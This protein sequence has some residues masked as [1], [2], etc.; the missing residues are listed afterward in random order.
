MGWASGKHAL[1]TGAG[2]GIG[3]AIAAALAGE[4]ASLSL[5]GRRREPLEAVAAAT[6]GTVIPCDITDRAAQEAAFA[7][8]RAANGAL[9]FLILNA[10]IADS[11][12]FARTSRASFDAI[13]ATNLTAAF[14]GAQIALPDL[15][16]GPGKRLIFIAS[17]AGLK[18][19]AYAA[20]Y[21]ASKHGVIGLMKS[22]AIEFAKSGMTVNA[23]CPSFVD[24]PMVDASVARVADRSGRSSEQARAAITAMN[25]SDR[26]ITADEVAAAALFLCRP[27][28]RSINGAALAIDGGTSA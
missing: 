10:G 17:V 24:T 26:L 20:P 12:P 18:G 14:D 1:V 28:S 11:A 16:A 27:E 23:I 15:L 22:L 4:G 6:G 9:D 21:V 8:A 13:L 19:S 3:A 5:L 25:A 7:A 2:S